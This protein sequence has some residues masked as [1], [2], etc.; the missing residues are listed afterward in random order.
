MSHMECPTPPGFVENAGFRPGF[1]FLDMLEFP[2]QSWHIWG[3]GVSLVFAAATW[4]A[5]LYLA[6]LNVKSYEFV[7]VFSKSDPKTQRH[8]L[9]VIL[10]PPVY[11]TLSWFSYLRYDYSTTIEFFATVFEAFAVYN[12]YTCLQAYLQPFRKEAERTKEPMTARMFHM[13]TVHVKSK[14]GMHYRIITDIL[15][16]QFPIWSIIDSFISIF[17]EYKGVYCQGSYSF[18]G[19]YVYLVIINF[20]SLSVILSAL[21]TYLAI[22]RNEWFEGKI[23]AHGMF[24]CVK[25]PIM[26]IFYFGQILLT[27][28]TS[29]KVIR[30]T[31]GTNSADS[32]A[33]PADAVKHG[34][35]VIIV[36]TVMVVDI[37]LMF[38]Y[39]GPTDNI[40]HARENGTEKMS[41]WRAITDGYLVYI[42]EFFYNLLCCGADSYRL[43][44]KRVELRKRKNRE[45]M[46][47]G[48]SNSSS[49]GNH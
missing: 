47:L 17:A 13:F 34:L 31:D 18:R 12:L 37:G 36:C 11:S 45:K 7:F 46:S 19:A 20:I 8:K 1:N 6:S 48:R 40:Q 49:A 22:Y 30:G 10:Y 28:L 4:I 16:L 38:K 27:G 3:W 24:W 14:W 35:Y 41:V 23:K 29:A 33:W 15:V 44:R 5:A 26:F 21:F 25:G 42:P 32:V 2:S 43:M 9:R 39:F